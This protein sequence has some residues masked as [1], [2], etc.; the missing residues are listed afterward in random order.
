MSPFLTREDE[1]VQYDAKNDTYYIERPYSKATLVSPL[2]LKTEKNDA[3]IPA[4]LYIG[5]VID[6]LERFQDKDGMP[7]N[8]IDEAIGHLEDTLVLLERRRDIIL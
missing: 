2:K 5:M 8:D 7:D 4:R 1:S 3:G 6:H